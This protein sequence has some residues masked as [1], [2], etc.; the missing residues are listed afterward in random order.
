[1]T[2]NLQSQVPAIDPSKD[3]RHMGHSERVLF[4]NGPEIDVMLGDTKLATLPKYILM[5]CSTKANKY[6]TDHAD[7]TSITFPESSMEAEF[8][9]LHLSWMD[10]MTYQGRVYSVTLNAELDA[11]NVKICQ[12]ARAMGLNNTYV[13][14]FTKILCDKIRTNTSSTE[15]MSMICEVANAENDPVFECLV[16]NLANQQMNKTAAREPEELALLSEKFPLFK[17]KMDV[18]SHRVKNARAGDRRK[19]RATRGPS[20]DR[21]GGAAPSSDRTTPVAHEERAHAVR[22]RVFQSFERVAYDFT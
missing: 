11:R 10:E 8:A 5:Q 16:N 4:A 19:A 17:E 12:A 18:I 2:F 9:K 6:F 20:H 21:N 3:I 7:A 1:M 14:H 15:F 13:G 22:R